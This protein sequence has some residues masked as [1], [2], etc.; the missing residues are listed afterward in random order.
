MSFHVFFLHVSLYKI[1]KKII[2]KNNM[3][4]VQKNYF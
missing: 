4:N 1:E 2:Y 3:Q